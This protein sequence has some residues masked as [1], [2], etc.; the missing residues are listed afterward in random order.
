MFATANNKVAPIFVSP[1]PDETAWAV[2]ALSISWDDLGLVYAFP[3]APIVAKTLDKIQKSSGTQV[4]MIASQSP[5]RPW[6]PILLQLSLRP[7]IPLQE[8][9]LYQY[10]PH[11]RSPVFHPDPRLFD[12]AAWM[13][14]SK[15]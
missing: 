7:R 13:L 8:L 11:R 10:L 15:L 1:Y 3:P 2:D 5:A 4:I 12:L 9:R 6:H 14:S